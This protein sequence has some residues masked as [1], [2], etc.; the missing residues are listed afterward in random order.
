MAKV[1]FVPS[2]KDWEDGAD[3]YAQN[4]TRFTSLHAT[5]LIGAMYTDIAKAKTIL[6]I[7]CGSGA[8]GFAYLDMFPNGIPGQTVIFSDLSKGMVTKC[9][10][11][12]ESKVVCSGEDNFQTKFVFQVE[13]A[14]ELSGIPDD[15]VDVA[16]SIFAVFFIPDQ[17]KTM[18][19]IQ[20]VLKKTNEED[21]GDSPFS[22]GGVLGLTAWTT[23]RDSS[24]SVEGEGFG[25]GFHDTMEAA[26]QKPKAATDVPAAEEE[27]PTWKRWFDPANIRPM[28]VDQAGFQTVE[29]YR[30][31]HTVTW[32]TFSDLWSMFADNPIGSIGKMSPE[33]LQE[34]KERMVQRTIGSGHGSSEHDKEHAKAPVFLWTASNLIIARGVP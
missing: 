27:I 6:D 8:F 29:I 17:A 21:D 34:A 31:I 2:K 11:L 12:L 32:K 5:D 23:L 19:T 28:I 10:E 16:V 1:S 9:Q 30:T 20:R 18:A 13:D 24:P 7:G 22:G 26:F 33:E 3:H 14:T 15:N 25:V 4:I